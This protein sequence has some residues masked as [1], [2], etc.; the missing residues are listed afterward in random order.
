MSAGQDRLQ[1]DFNVFYGN[2]N[3][4]PTEPYENLSYA[5]WGT[6]TFDFLNLL[7][8]GIEGSI[9]D[10]IFNNPALYMYLSIILLIIIHL[11]TKT[12]DIYLMYIPNLLNILAIFFSTPIQ[13]YRYLYP[14][15]L[16]CYVLIII[17]IWLRYGSSDEPQIS[18]NPIEYIKKLKQ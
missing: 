15:L 14:N 13:D 6:P 1:S 11:V 4:I 7:S 17:V 10:T 8:L 16:V 3:N 18:L 12:R 9:F 5:N 2:H